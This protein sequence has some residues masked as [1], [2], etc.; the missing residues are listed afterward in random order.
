MVKAAIDTGVV[1]EYIDELGLL[2][3]QASILFSA[4]LAG[5]IELI[6]PH[7]ILAETYYVAARVYSKLG[8]ENPG[9]RASKLVEWL[10]RLPT[11]T[12]EE[13]LDL[14][15]EAGRIKHTYKIALTDCYVLAASKIHMCT[16]VFRKPEK[17]MLPNIDSLTREFKILFL[18]SYK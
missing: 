17:E 18:E 14:A 5:M 2:H 13:G 15:L 11:V 6:I 16:A 12:V 4:A 3:Q 8:Y 10:Y 1:I 9:D 7:P